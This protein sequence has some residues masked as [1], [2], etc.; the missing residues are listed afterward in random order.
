MRSD[1]PTTWSRLLIELARLVYE[2]P[3]LPRSMGR[4]FFHSTACRAL[5]AT[6]PRPQI[7]EVPAAS[8]HC[9]LLLWGNTLLPSAVMTTGRVVPSG[10]VS[11]S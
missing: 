11:E 1:T 9:W 8:A 4:P 3:K 6:R 7:P 10:S 2:P 5:V